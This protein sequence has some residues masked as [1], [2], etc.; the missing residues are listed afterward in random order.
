MKDCV[1]WNFMEFERL[2]Q[3]TATERYTKNRPA[4]KAH[5]GRF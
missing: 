5:A 3:Y 1:A 2:L 4:Y